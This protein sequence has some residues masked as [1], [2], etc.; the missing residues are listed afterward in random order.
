M[1]TPHRVKYPRTPH[2]PW[3]PGV[4]DDDV[5]GAELAFAGELVVVTEKMDGENTTMYRDGV[6]ARSI[7]SAMHPSRAWV[8]ALHGQVGWRIP[9]G[10]RVCG[11]N[12]FARHSIGYDALPSYFLVFSV[13]T[14]ADECLSWAETQAFCADLE[15]HTVPVFY[16]GPWDERLV[17]GMAVDPERTEGYVVRLARRFA[18]AEFQRGVAKW[19]RP[20]HVQTDEHWMR[21]AVVPNGL[22]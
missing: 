16:E 10:W 5:V 6:H 18:F 8:R 17:R 21:Q 22:L 13:W 14:D 2:L 7:D 12:L 19:V 3:S 1:P 11:E 15:L 9:E 4:S 20:H